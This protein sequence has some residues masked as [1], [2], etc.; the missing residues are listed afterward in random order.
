MIKSYG[1][2]RG[3]G[4][5]SGDLCAPGDTVGGSSD[6][7]RCTTRSAPIRLVSTRLAASSSSTQRTCPSLQ[8]TPQTRALSLKASFMARPSLTCVTSLRTCDL[9]AGLAAPQLSATVGP[10]GMRERGRSACD[11][12]AVAMARPS[13]WAAYPR[14][15]M[16]RRRRPVR[17]SPQR[18]AILAG[19]V[20]LDPAVEG[21]SGSPAGSSVRASASRT[22]LQDD[23]LHSSDGYVNRH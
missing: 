9:G 4:G 15:S 3:R 8:W 6:V 10:A 14:W 19:Q 5:S 22:P 17:V 7:A 1:P 12:S 11:R 16:G 18:R 23:L 20:L 13:A 2:L 21:R